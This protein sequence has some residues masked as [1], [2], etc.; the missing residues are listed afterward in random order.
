MRDNMSNRTGAARGI[1]ALCLSLV[2]STAARADYP[3]AEWVPSPYLME[4]RSFED[5]KTDFVHHGPGSEVA[6]D[7]MRRLDG[8]ASLRWQWQPGAEVEFDLPTPQLTPEL[9]RKLYSGSSATVTVFSAWVYNERPRPG[10]ALRFEFGRRASGGKAD[11]WFDFKLGFSG[12]RTCTPAFEDSM[13]GKAVPGMDFVRI[14]A[15]KDA[16]GRVWLDRLLMAYDE[17]RWQGW[18]AD[19]QVDLKNCPF[20][21][22]V[23]IDLGLP[24]KLPKPTPAELDGLRRVQSKLTE[25]MAGG[26]NQPPAAWA[27]VKRDYDQLALERLPDGSTLGPHMGFNSLLLF[28]AE[29][30]PHVQLR[31]YGALMIQVAKLHTAAID[32]A[33]RAALKDMFLTLCRHLVDQ[34]FAR[35]SALG[36]THHFGYSSREWSQAMFLASNSPELRGSSDYQD[37]LAG[38]LWFDRE[39][40]GGFSSDVASYLT[41][42][43]D[44][45]DY[46]NTMAMSHLA[47]ILSQSSDGARVFLLRKYS[48]FVSATLAR[49]GPGM[50]GGLK[51]DGAIFH[52]GAIYPAYA[53]GLLYNCPLL[54]YWFKDTPFALDPAALLGLRKAVLA[55]D[56]FSN[57]TSGIG[58]CGRHPLAGAGLPSDGPR[59]LALAGDLFTGA[60]VDKDMAA[61]YLRRVPEARADSKKL[62]GEDIAPAPAPQGHW[63]FNYGC[64]GVHRFQDKMVTLKGFSKDVWC[65][66][67]YWADNRYGRYQSYGGVQIMPSTTNGGNGFSN[68]G[69]DWNLNPGA[70][71]ILLPFELL[72]APG[73]RFDQKTRESFSGS[74]NLEGRY[75]AFGF[76]LPP[77]PA[78]IKN[79]DPAFT[80]RK[81]VFCFDDRLV[82]LGSGIASSD[83]KH[84]VATVLYQHALY[85]KA[86]PTWAD[87]PAPIASFPHEG[88]AA[89]GGWLLDGYGNGYLLGDGVA[90]KFTRKRQT[91]VDD[92]TNWDVRKMTEGDFAAAWIDHGPAPKDAT[93]EYL[94]VLDATP[95]KMAG[96]AAARPYQVLR[97]DDIAHAV[98]DQATGVTGAVLW[99]PSDKLGV[100]PLLSTRLPAIVMFREDAPGR[101][102][103]SVCDPDLNYGGCD[104]MSQPKCHRLLLDGQWRAAGAKNGK[105]S[106]KAEGANTALEVVCRDGQPVEFALEM[107]APPVKGDAE[108][109][110]EAP[111]GGL[112]KW[113]GF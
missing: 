19:Y 69:W 32:P 61:V 39:F 49:P 75:G 59:Y 23:E 13:E 41:G 28:G 15:P 73:P 3:A 78:P 76:H 18:S 42:G 102:V 8:K 48:A 79:L 91:S 68:S 44:V 106:L 5:G 54:A 86:T 71:V 6:V 83:Q 89:P 82:C 92:H 88:M 70:T 17:L 81:S 27:Q 77:L 84:P 34:G 29:R 72:D 90:A 31:D 95:A 109:K 55:T 98:R 110:G 24:K 37:A 74:S 50:S 65:S 25:M 7:T 85:N 94:V 99:K 56:V 67:I 105:V 66:E 46:Y 10:E 35:G 1:A 112:L 9:A 12:W 58:L 51:P 38:L 36:R 108:H 40:K 101:L 93:Y 96:L 16:T 45:C 11:C 52:H 53:C 20:T 26:D 97:R 80:A 14:K 57:P 2:A 113:L 111:Q 104:G 60:P 21:P 63:T 100:P 33:H 4:A 103:M 87:N 62:F 107:A 47:L 22:A 64:L 43:F 30:L